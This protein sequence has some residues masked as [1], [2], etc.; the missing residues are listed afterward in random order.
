M[1][2]RAIGRGVPEHKIA[3]A[4]SLNVASVQRRTRLL[5]EGRPISL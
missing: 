1:I 5:D 4:L 2:V 3:K